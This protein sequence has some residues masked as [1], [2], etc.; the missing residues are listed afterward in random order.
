MMNFDPTHDYA[1]T[2]IS[3]VSFR[4]PPER[5]PGSSSPAQRRGGGGTMEKWK[6]EGEG[7]IF[8]QNGCYPLESPCT[9]DYFERWN[10]FIRPVLPELE[11][12]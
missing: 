6:I 1:G 9:A 3:E 11:H 10:G 2:S 8:R 4:P 7:G 5:V 12:F